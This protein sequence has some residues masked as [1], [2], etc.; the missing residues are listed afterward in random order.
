MPR[1]PDRRLFRRCQECGHVGPAADF[2]R[3]PAP[4][5]SES[6][7]QRMRCPACGHVGPRVGFPTAEPPEGEPT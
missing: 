7:L 3:P 6:P 2:K 1:W 4:V 5:G